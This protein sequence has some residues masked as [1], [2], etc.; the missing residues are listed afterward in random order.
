MGGEV[1]VGARVGDDSPGVEEEVGKLLFVETEEERV[2]RAERGGRCR[3]GGFEGR[4]R[5]AHVRCS[6][7]FF[8]GLVGWLGLKVV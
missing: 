7:F 3:G 4:D 1:G 8:V 6:P 5:D 2:G